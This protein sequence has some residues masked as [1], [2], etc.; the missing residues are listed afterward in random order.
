MVPERDQYIPYSTDFDSVVSATELAIR[1]AMRSRPVNP[2]DR[3]MEEHGK[4]MMKGL[5]DKISAGSSI[6]LKKII[7]DIVRMQRSEGDGP[8]QVRRLR[9]YLETELEDVDRS[10]SRHD[11]DT[12]KKEPIL[13]IANA[14]INRAVRDKRQALQAAVRVLDLRQG[15]ENV[16]DIFDEVKDAVH[17]FLAEQTD[18]ADKA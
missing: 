5:F 16:G 7:D 10:L 8:R 9:I 12:E 1:A 14:I 2:G 17:F 18:A 13:G 4:E 15:D 6:F 11:A 3:E